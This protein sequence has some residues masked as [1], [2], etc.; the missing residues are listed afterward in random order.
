[1]GARPTAG[2]C[3]FSQTISWVCHPLSACV[4]C[5][6][7]HTTSDT[8]SRCEATRIRFFAQA[9]CSCQNQFVVLCQS[10]DPEKYK[11]H[12]FVYIAS[13]Q[14]DKVP[15]TFS[16]RAFVARV[17]KPAKFQT[18]HR[19]GQ[20]G[21]KASSVDCPGLAPLDVQASIQ[22]FKG[23]HNELSNL[24]MCSEGCAWQMNGVV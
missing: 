12:R 16:C 11:G 19:C 23:G 7:S 14:L 20:V 4:S 18:C 5:F 8:I 1:M 21:H 3:N 6:S 10:T 2:A 24:H 22:P 17:I 15:Q 9:Q 13:D